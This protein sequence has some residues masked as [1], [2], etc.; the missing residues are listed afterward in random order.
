MIIILR[1]IIIKIITYINITTV[2]KQ[3]FNIIKSIG[4][5]SYGDVYLTNN[6]YGGKINKFI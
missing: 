1:N 2:E 4:K 3:E 6:N 5:G